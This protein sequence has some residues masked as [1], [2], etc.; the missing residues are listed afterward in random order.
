MKKITK[1]IDQIAAN[2]QLFIPP[3]VVFELAFA[4][5]METIT[6]ITAKAYVL[7]IRLINSRLKVNNENTYVPL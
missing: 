1:N 6:W 4:T 3:S 5:T 7:M 2:A